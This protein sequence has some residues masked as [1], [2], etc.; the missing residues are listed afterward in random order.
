[1]QPLAGLQSGIPEKSPCRLR[2]GAPLQQASDVPPGRTQAASPR[3]AASRAWL[4]GI[5]KSN[6]AHARRFCQTDR[7]AP[8][9]NG[10]SSG[11]NAPSAARPAR[12]IVVAALA[13]L[14]EPFGLIRT[15]GEP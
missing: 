6:E 8:R 14:R 12:F 2:S 15:P 13:H 9:K 3:L 7:K 4:P 10:G 5:G 1:M 11:L